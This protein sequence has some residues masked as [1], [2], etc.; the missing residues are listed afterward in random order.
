MRH[1]SIS[2]RSGF[3]LVEVL[4]AM[5]IMLVGLLGLLQSINISMEHNVKNH[6]REEATRVGE[7]E[8]N[9]FR[10]NP[11]VTALKRISST[12][13]PNKSFVVTK[14]ATPFAGSQELE[15]VVRWK[16]KNMSTQHMVRSILSN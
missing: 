14:T 15:V 7:R 11:G 4:V 8:M 13:L 3:T 12:V 9:V 10:T 16:F 5:V 6:L 1:L 2:N